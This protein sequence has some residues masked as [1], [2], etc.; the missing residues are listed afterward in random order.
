[1][2]NS[3]TKRLFTKDD[4]PFFRDI[5]EKKRE[6]IYRELGYLEENS[7]RPLDEY[8]GDNS[9]YSLH[10]A[11]QG[12]D[13]QEREKA[14]LFAARENKFLNHLNRAI[15]RIDKGEYGFCIDCKSPIQYARLEAVPHATL[16]I[17]CKRKREEAEQQL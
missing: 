10:M 13:A 4:A 3:T 14:F 15:E 1:M 11:D 12:T 2:E 7:L 6:K 16:C 17:E 5:I 9:T 8:S